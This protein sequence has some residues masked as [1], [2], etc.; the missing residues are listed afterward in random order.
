[1]RMLNL[2][3]TICPAMFMLACGHVA[4]SQP[5]SES[6]NRAVCAAQSFL[7]TNGYLETAASTDRSKLTLEI[8]DRLKYG[9]NG[10]IDWDRLLTERKGSFVGK[11]HAVMRSNDAF[12]VV[13]S[14]VPNYTCLDVESDFVSFHLHEANCKPQSDTLKLVKENDLKCSP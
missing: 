8:W 1:M 4:L 12:V 6:E 2:F 5:L 11:L 13:Y 10:A 9:K 3:V 7:R 14:F